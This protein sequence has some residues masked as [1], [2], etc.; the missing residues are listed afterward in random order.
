MSDQPPTNDE[1]NSCRWALAVRYESEAVAVLI[2]L[3]VAEKTSREI[4]MIMCFSAHY[5][6]AMLLLILVLGNFYKSTMRLHPLLALTI[7]GLMRLPPMFR[8]FYQKQ[9][10][11]HACGE[12]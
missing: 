7:L 2:F 11:R 6:N 3:A 8:G 10:L 1:P 5:P 12:H 4:L 9:I